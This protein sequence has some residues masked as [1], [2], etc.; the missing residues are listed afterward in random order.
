MI[1]A[2]GYDAQG[3]HIRNSWGGAWGNGG[4]AKLSWSFITRVANGGY[5]VNGIRTPATPIA[6]APTV[7]A[8]STAKAAP[9]TAVTITGAG[10]STAT[11]V[12]FGGTPAT[13][14]RR[15]STD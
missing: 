5:A 7:G 4:D 9:G 15:P 2:Y 6:M 14:T 12:S 13:F 3:V 11:A 1:A 10:L 8:L